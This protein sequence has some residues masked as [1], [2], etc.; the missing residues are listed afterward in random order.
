LGNPA[1]RQ[2][3]DAQ[4]PEFE[5]AREMIAARKYQ[6]G[7]TPGEVAA[8][9]GTTPTQSFFN[10]ISCRIMVTGDSV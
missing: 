9:M 8:R 5:L 6:A 1:V 4:A 3:Y 7:L 10:I 2:A